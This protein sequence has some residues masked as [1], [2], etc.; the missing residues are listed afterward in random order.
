MTSG[1]C[2][3]AWQWSLV[4]GLGAWAGCFG[5][6][7]PTNAVGSRDGGSAYDGDAAV[8]V[9]PAR[10][11]AMVC[12]RMG[13]DPSGEPFHYFL[14]LQEMVDGRFRVDCSAGGSSGTATSFRERLDP[15]KD[16]CQEARAGGCGGGNVMR[17]DGGPTLRRFFEYVVGEEGIDV[18]AT[19]ETFDDSEEPRTL[20]FTIPFE[21]CRAPR[22]RFAPDPDEPQPEFR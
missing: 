9:Q 20:A 11:C 16:E 5:S 22:S 15:T 1:S 4:V 3:R 21:E 17:P 10:E 8:V 18:V 2:R 7:S 6:D 12:S 14:S 13:E 19:I